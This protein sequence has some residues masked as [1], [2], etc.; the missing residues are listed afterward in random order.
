MDLFLD[1]KRWQRHLKRRKNALSFFLLVRKNSIR[2]S[3]CHSC[4]K[5]KN[6]N[7]WCPTVFDKRKNVELRNTCSKMIIL[8]PQWCRRE[9]WR[10]RSAR[11][12]LRYP[13]CRRGVPP[14]PGCT[15]GTRSPQGWTPATERGDYIVSTTTSRWYW[16][17]TLP[18]GVDTCN[19]EGGLYSQYHHIQVVLV[20]HAPLRFKE[21]IFCFL[22]REKCSF[23]CT[24]NF[25]WL[26]DV[27]INP[28]K[29][30]ENSWVAT[31]AQ[32]TV[33]IIFVR[34]EKICMAPF[35]TFHCLYTIWS[36]WDHM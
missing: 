19:R 34:W 9:I 31:G 18:S 10:C 2:T 26:R 21:K 15:G 7:Y 8:H 5:R 16:W 4:L 11:S 17:D 12:T 20:G 24:G 14:P 6:L 30:L 33:A 28:G 3:F 27:V 36:K 1:G 13:G 25:S 22:S 32:A 23:N 29:L 35:V